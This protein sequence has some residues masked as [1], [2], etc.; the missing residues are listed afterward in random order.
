MSSATFN[1]MTPPAISKAGIETPKALRIHFPPK[2]NKTSTKKVTT[3][4]SRAIRTRSRVLLRAVMARKV[5]M[6]P[7]GSTITNKD[8]KERIMKLIGSLN[9]NICSTTFNHKWYSTQESD[10]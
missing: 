5:G 9:S 7:T 10:N 6:A 3:E 8:Q 1:K 4:A 2:E